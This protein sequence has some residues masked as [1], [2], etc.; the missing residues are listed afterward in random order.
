MAFMC[1]AICWML[2]AWL[3]RRWALLGGMFAI[4]HA[5]FG[6]GN[7]WAQ[8]Y[9]G[10]AVGAGGGALLLGGVRYLMRE[11]RKNYAM[12]MG[13]GLAILANSRPYEGLVL[14]LPVG[15]GLLIW[16][17]EKIGLPST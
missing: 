9:C 12:V 11:P 14:S 6:V 2:Q 7:Y 10:G 13:V 1:A 8:S 5:N 17:S 3:P 16:C 15:L 4:I